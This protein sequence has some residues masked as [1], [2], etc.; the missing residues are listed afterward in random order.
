MENSII[1][2]VSLISLSNQG[3]DKIRGIML[4]LPDPITLQLHAKAFRKMKNLKFLM[5]HNVHIC[6]EL[7]YLPNGLTLVQWPESPFSLVFIN[8]DL[9]KFY[10]N[11]G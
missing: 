11:V 1:L 4:H 2:Y 3:S 8:Y 9:F 10:L 5:V 6:G 7:E